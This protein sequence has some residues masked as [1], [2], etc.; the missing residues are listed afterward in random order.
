MVIHKGAHLPHAR[1]GNM[2]TVLHLQGNDVHVCLVMR[3]GW[4]LCFCVGQA[5]RLWLSPIQRQH[6]TC[7]QA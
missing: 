4:C 7:A 1:S 5:F 6:V 2:H 3:S